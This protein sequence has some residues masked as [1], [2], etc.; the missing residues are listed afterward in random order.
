MLLPLLPFLTCS[1]TQDVHAWALDLRASQFAVAISDRNT[2]NKRS[3]WSASLQLSLGSCP[4]ALG[5]RSLE[6]LCILLRKLRVSCGNVPGRISCSL[7][8]CWSSSSNRLA[9]DCKR[10]CRKPCAPNVPDSCLA[11]MNDCLGSFNFALPV[12]SRATLSGMQPALR[13]N[14]HDSAASH[15]ARHSPSTS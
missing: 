14:K 13:L 15:H 8:S 3:H 9:K 11:A 1:S 5:K 6:S 2:N 12:W 7:R 10:R 4:A